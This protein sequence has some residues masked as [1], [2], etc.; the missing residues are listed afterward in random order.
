MSAALEQLCRL[1][2]VLPAYHDIWGNMHNTSEDASRAF[3]KAMGVD[4]TTD[5]EAQASL[6]AHENQRW[7]STLPPVQVVRETEM[8]HC[9]PIVFPESDNG[10]IY[11]WRL[12]EETGAIRSGQFVQADILE[13]ER[14]ELDGHGLVRR[15]L[16]F[17]FDIKPGYH[18][19]VLEHD[20]QNGAVEDMSFIVVPKECYMPQA[21]RNDDG[22][23]WGLATQLYG[24]RSER[25]W[26][27]GDFGDLLDMIEF[28]GKSGADAVLLNPLHAL[29]PDAPSHA[30][31][32]S[33][34]HRAYL[35]T[36]YIDVQRVDE[37]DECDEAKSVVLSS[38][39]QEALRTLR[40]AEQVDYFAVADA[41]SQVLNQLYDSF[42]ANHLKRNTDRAK[43]FLKFQ[44]AHG[45]SL[46]D[47]AV[48]EALQEHFRAMDESV[49][50][51]PVWPE[52]YRNRHS[53]EVAE[54]C[55]ANLERVEYF[56]YLQWQA[57][58][59]LAD[60]GR[61]T[62]ECGL[63]VG[64]MLDLAIGVSEGGAATWAHPELYA[65]S[66]SA[67]APPD[68]FNLHGQD[69]GLPPW[70]PHR[71][72]EVAYEPF[73]ELLRENMKNAGALRIDHVMGL[74]RMFWVA[75]TMSANEGAYVLYPFQDLLGILALESHRN[76]CMVV[77]ED[78]GTVPDEVRHAL[79]P[80]NVLSTRLFYFE[81]WGD[82]SM[83]PPQEYPANALAAVTTHDLPTLIGYWRG[84]DIELRSRLNL[85][86]SDEMQQRQANSRPSD[87]RHMLAAL[88][89]EGLLPSGL[90]LGEEGNPEMT[91][92]LA[93][94][95]YAYLAR[96]PSKLV[97][98]QIEDALGVANPPN[99]PG[100]T[101]AD[102]PCWRLKLPVEIERWAGNPILQ[103]ITGA[104][105][106]ERPRS[107]D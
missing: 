77:G 79:A 56:E 60:A 2:G 34:S 30:S 7:S 68:D 14:Y 15:Q 4:A 65:L 87:R 21:I 37:F 1:Y 63:G 69:W 67:G 47:L 82:G 95:I 58:K 46:R 103:Q 24:V 80:M 49:W 11:R 22:R 16:N 72:T 41:K 81:R 91:A 83:K 51:W 107:S 53:P 92:D 62:R 97:L 52:Q 78:L 42:R 73:I 18:R 13:I 59:Q 10:L 23:V 32:Y 9:V 50:G 19:L 5:E 36:L 26:G 48:F 71:L 74:R 3:L 55:A 70:I 89:R 86:P 93:A 88:D 66:A 57:E 35:N 75:R 29:F 12:E 85:Y 90:E 104:L 94:A 43:A 6:Q 28:C 25:N 44:A 76:Q 105:R 98:V 102:Y 54:F 17:D 45:G 61:Y 8:P 106:R 38:A 101:E 64:V 99:V 96:T 39:F 20:G 100:T 27:M 33:P 40:S 31:P 84:L